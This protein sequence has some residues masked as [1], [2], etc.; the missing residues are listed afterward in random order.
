MVYV[1]IRYGKGGEGE[2]EEKILRFLSTEMVAEQR[3][4]P[5]QVFLWY[6]PKHVQHG[7]LLRNALYLASGRF[8]IYSYLRNAS[9]RTANGWKIASWDADV[10]MSVERIYISIYPTTTV[11]SEDNTAQNIHPYV[12]C[13]GKLFIIWLFTT[14]YKRREDNFT[15]K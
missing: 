10:N 2:R 9:F 8:R 3:T 11:S 7:R 4:I 12:S 5:H 14:P 13:R 1:D 15:P 6:Q